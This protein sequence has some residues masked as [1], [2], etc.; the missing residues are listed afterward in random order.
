LL[1]VVLLPPVS[2]QVLLLLAV[3]VGRLRH[4]RQFTPVSRH[5]HR[6]VVVVVVVSSSS[7]SSLSLSSVLTGGAR[8]HHTWSLRA[9]AWRVGGGQ[10]RRFRQHDTSATSPPTHTCSA[11]NTTSQTTHGSAQ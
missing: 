8:S 3:S 2:L 6:R 9:S 4:T 1:Q 10:H 5:R 7:S 11:K